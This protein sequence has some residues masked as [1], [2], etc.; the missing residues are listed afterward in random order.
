MILKM[1]TP[2]AGLDHWGFSIELDAEIYH[3]EIYSNKRANG[4][5]FDLFDSTRAPLLRGA[6]LVGG[7]DLLHPYRYRAVPPGKLF[8]Q[9][10]DQ[11]ATDP[12]LTAFVEGRAVLYY[13]TAT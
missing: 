3:F 1:P 5:H 10:S 13:Q 9:S 6:A 2:P 11:P 7:V 8:V 4:W 12:D